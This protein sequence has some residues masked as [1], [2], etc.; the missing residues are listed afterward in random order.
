MLNIIFE[1]WKAFDDRFGR[2]GKLREQIRNLKAPGILEVRFN[3]ILE[4]A[5]S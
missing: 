4:L 5:D 1:L 2:A 3:L